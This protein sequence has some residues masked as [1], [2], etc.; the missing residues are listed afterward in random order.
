MVSS[1]G[2]IVARRATLAQIPGVVD[3]LAAVKHLAAL[4]QTGKGRLVLS[5]DKR[6]FRNAERTNLKIEGVDGR[7]LILANISGNG[8]ISVRLSATRR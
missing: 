1:L 2:D 3:R 7:Y 4:P 8:K 5:P 6:T